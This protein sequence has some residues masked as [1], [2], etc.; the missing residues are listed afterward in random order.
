MQLV[1]ER[2]VPII[3]GD[4]IDGA[5][6]AVGGTLI[7]W[8]RSHPG[9]VISR[10]TQTS[11][12]CVDQVGEPVGAAFVRADS[13]IEIVDARSRAIWQIFPHSDCR[14]VYPIPAGVAE[15]LTAARGDDGW[16]IG[17][18]DTHG[19]S[20]LYYF[21]S[22]RRSTRRVLVSSG[23]NGDPVSLR[24]GYLRTVGSF[25]LLSSL[26]WPFE[27][28]RVDATGQRSV[29]GRPAGDW[30]QRV[31]PGGAINQTV[32]DSMRYWVGLA[33]MPLDSGFVQTI[34]DP[35]SDH[36]EIILYAK[37][38]NVVRASSVS[39]PLGILATNPKSLTLI[40]ARDVD[41][42]EIVI[43]RWHWVR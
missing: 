33:A 16:F 5:T 39:V 25:A 14:K 20:G 4:Q 1:E 36:R 18:V 40:A 28:E 23:R 43:Y 29:G 7:Y 17:G 13:A 27:W 3:G 19:V 30:S 9:L 24:R 10:G 26:Q 37:N 8:S 38:G 41:K 11:R 34:A 42:M 32:Q 12:I 2:V 6:I 31:V 22:L 21:D 15:I 35:T